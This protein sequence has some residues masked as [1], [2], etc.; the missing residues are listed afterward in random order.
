MP[1]NTTGVAV[2]YEAL[3][4]GG[5]QVRGACGIDGCERAHFAVFSLRA[6]FADAYYTLGIHLENI[7]TGIVIQGSSV[8]CRC[9]DGSSCWS[10]R[11]AR[12]FCESCWHDLTFGAD[13]APQIVD[14]PYLEIPEVLSRPIRDRVARSER[15]TLA[16]QRSISEES[17]ARD[18]EIPAP[19]IIGQES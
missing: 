18:C 15:L 10:E 13:I 14:S 6:N 2:H 3:E 11:N 17:Q 19:F 5:I 16:L 7:P 1:D 4:A 9:G 8:V 12:W